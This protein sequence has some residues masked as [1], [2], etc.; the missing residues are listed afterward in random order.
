MPALY[1][2]TIFISTSLTS[3]ALHMAKYKHKTL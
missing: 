1:V 3:L 2:K